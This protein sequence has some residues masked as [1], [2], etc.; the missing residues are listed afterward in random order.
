MTIEELKQKAIGIFKTGEAYVVS[1]DKK[2]ESLV[3]SYN[4]DDLYESMI[5]FK[6]AK[7]LGKFKDYILVVGKYVEKVKFQNIPAIRDYRVK[8]II[9]GIIDAME[10]RLQKDLNNPVI[11][12]MSDRTKY[13]KPGEKTRFTF[14]DKMQSFTLLT[15]GEIKIIENEIENLLTDKIND[16]SWLSVGEFCFQWIIEKKIENIL[17]LIFSDLFYISYDPWIKNLPEIIRDTGLLNKLII[18]KYNE[19]QKL[20]FSLDNEV[21]KIINKKNLE[22]IS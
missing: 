10:Y 14:N 12:H 1:Q 5:E 6:N 16:L 2:V 8:I 18:E 3:L 17:Y 13:I 22:K 15:T 20:N 19:S 21:K 11:T 9:D 7:K 4:P